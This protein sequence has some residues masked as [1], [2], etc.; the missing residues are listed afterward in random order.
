MEKLRLLSLSDDL[1]GKISSYLCD[2]PQQIVA[3]SLTCQYL[4]HLIHFRSSHIWYD[5]YSL[6]LS[7]VNETLK[8]TPQISWKS[9]FI[10]IYS[11]ISQ[12]NHPSSYQPIHI[13]HITPP[14]LIPR[15]GHSINSFH[16][17]YIVQFGGATTDYIM[18]N[19]YD[20]FTILPDQSLQFFQIDQDFSFPF[21]ARRWLHTGTSIGS[22]NRRK[23]VIYG[24]MGN[25]V[26][27]GDLLLL[28][29]FLP[30]DHHA[31]N[32][33]EQEDQPKV[34]CS[35]ALSSPSSPS[36]SP[37]AGHSAVV[38][39]QRYGPDKSIFIFGGR[40]GN[41]SSVEAL[42]NEIWHLDCTGCLDAS[43]TA[44]WRKLLPTGAPPC[45]RWCHSALRNRD[46]MLVFGGWTHASEGPVN[47]FLNDL[48]LFDFVNETWIEIVTSGVPPCPR[49]QAPVMFW[50]SLLT[51]SYAP[52]GSE[53]ETQS[54]QNG[55][56]GY[57][58]I[59]GGAYH[60][61]QEEEI[62][63]PYGSRV[64]DS[65]SFHVLDLNSFT[66]LPMTQT[67]RPLRGGVNGVLWAEMAQ[68]WVLSG[69]SHP[70]QS[71]FPSFQ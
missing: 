51:G 70:H 56:A 64:I 55:G 5:L 44:V 39:D 30:H 9:F 52:R 29:L 54:S 45:R 36:P 3:L 65:D 14:I 16:Q 31:G 48:F 61:T 1:I 63:L 2:T 67:Y 10:E 19:S 33:N 18:T 13:K 71:P 60:A 22:K 35:R 17:N 15:S 62:L 20:L 58:A 69:K 6:H 66:W 7:R 57:L 53:D 32:E 41:S 25:H 27:N 12:K 23:V 4:Y 49:C 59:Y 50:N 38:W 46:S 47:V 28:E 43:H 37:R 26:L 34:I 21:I 68:C 8:Y 42:S 24:G 40:V 11:F